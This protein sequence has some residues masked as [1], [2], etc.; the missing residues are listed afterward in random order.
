MIKTNKQLFL[1]A[2]SKLKEQFLNELSLV[3]SNLADGLR[4]VKAKWYEIKNAEE[5]E[6]NPQIFIYG[7]IGGWWGI[8]AEEFVKEL[9]SIGAKN[10]DVRINSPGGSL[11]DGI[12][13]YNAL[14]KHPANMT[15]YVDSIAASAASIIAMGG[16]EVVMMV[17]S[18]MMIHDALGIEIGNAADFLEM[19]KFL[20]RQSDNIAGVYKARAG[21][22][23]KDWRDRM[24]AET[25][26]FADEAIALGLADRVYDKKTDQG[27]TSVDAARTDDHDIELEDSA[28]PIIDLVNQQY[29][30]SKFGY[31]HNGRHDAPPPINSDNLDSLID[32]LQSALGKV[33]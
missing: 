9:N 2:R 32:M 20:D 21:G 12:G 28:K 7:S 19:S 30:L 25:W 17:G 10:I 22:T 5:E 26:M 18:Q 29:D 6:G 27:G 24:L 33:G 3:N 4:K 1:D 8:D 11:F 31:K 13:I 23:V 16:D 14:V 15:V